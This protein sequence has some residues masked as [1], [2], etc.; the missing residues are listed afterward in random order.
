MKEPYGKFLKSGLVPAALIA[1]AGILMVFF[2]KKL[3]FLTVF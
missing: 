1:L 2:S 3:G